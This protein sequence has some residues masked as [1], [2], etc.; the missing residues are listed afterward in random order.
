MLRHMNSHVGSAMKRL[1][2]QAAGPALIVTF[3]LAQACGSATAQRDAVGIVSEGGSPA[4]DA[5]AGN[6]SEAASLD[7]APGDAKGDASSPQIAKVCSALASRASCPNQESESCAGKGRCIY[8]ANMHPES[9]DAFV[10]CYAF[11]SCGTR[12][13]C[14]AEAGKVRQPPNDT[15]V[16]DCFAKR[17][18]CNNNFD[19]DLCSTSVY[20]WYG[21]HAQALDCLAKDCS[22]IETCFEA[23]EQSREECP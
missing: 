20:A 6:D 19:D 22:Q 1:L 9:T 11:P 17:A 7:A 2:R 14:R 5:G 23:L 12:D 21:F 13:Q 18:L 4:I 16:N 10:D 8:A 3:L 15:W